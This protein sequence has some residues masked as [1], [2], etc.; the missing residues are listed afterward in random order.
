MNSVLRVV[1]ET[2]IIILDLVARSLGE[3]LIV[4]SC[5]KFIAYVDIIEKR[6]ILLNSLYQKL[7]DVQLATT[8]SSIFELHS[9]HAVLLDDKGLLKLTFSTLQ[10]ARIFRVDPLASNDYQRGNDGALLNGEF[11]FGSM[12]FEPSSKSGELFVIRKGKVEKIDCIGIPNTFVE[13]DGKVLVSDSLE[14]VIYAYDCLS[15]ERT[16]W[17]DFSN[18]PK[19]PDGG[20]RSSTGNVL[21][22][23][24]GDQSLVEFT[25]G[26]KILREFRLPV[27][28]PTN[29]CE[30]MGKLVVTSAQVDLPH[31]YKGE[32]DG[33][34]FCFEI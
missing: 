7:V 25:P 29:C 33:K 32:L 31:S 16:V 24:W 6:F 28:N 9:D 4:S 19:I 3:G 22:A 1:D 18:T 8:P 21:I 10:A 15:F 26:G 27:L 5:G 30:W 34:T 17:A 11:W 20:F 23:M 2:N 14:Q 12:G 13:I